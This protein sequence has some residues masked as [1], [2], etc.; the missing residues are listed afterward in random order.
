[1]DRLS[2]QEL[3]RDYSERRSEPA[4]AELV[5]RHVDLVYSA[6]LRMVGDAHLAEDVTQGAFSALAQNA[7]QLSDRSVLAG[8]LHRTARNLAA[9][10]VRG[11][12]RRR[13]REQ[14]AAAMN[15]L[16]STES[17]AVWEK[18]APHL[19]AALDDLSEPD[20]DALLL[21]YFER[22]SAHEIA[23]AF[24]ISDDAAQKR[25]SRAVERLREFFSKR[26]VA[27]GASGVVI[28][29]SA[30]AVQAAPI[31][32][33]A[34]ISSTAILTGTTATT[35][36]ATKAIAMTLIQ[37]TL[38]AATVTALVGTSVYEAHRTAQLGEQ[39]QTLQQQQAPLTAQ[40]QELQQQ[41]D[42]ASNQVASLT[43]ELAKSDKNDFEL[44]K[45]RGEVG[46]LRKQLA[47]VS[48]TPF[49]KSKPA[50]NP[51]TPD[52]AGQ[53]ASAIAQ[54]DPTALRRLN[55]FAKSQSQY[56]QTNSV[57]LKNEELTAVWSKSFSGL[58]AAFDS[59]S[60]E[61]IKGNVNAR[62]AIDQAT[63][64]GPLQGP[65]VTSLGKLAAKGDESALQM[66]L[67]PD[68]NGILLSSVVGALGPAAENGNPQAIAF[69]ANVLSDQTK[70]PL[71]HMASEPLRTAAAF[72]NQS[73][74]DALK[75][76]P[77]QP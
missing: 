71:W 11:D 72:G 44:L 1:M 56:Y 9:N 60:D 35:V 17:D 45:L 42:D 14:E 64:L 49:Q 2:D 4:F 23:Q 51:A 46:A 39:V 55:D 38:I 34:S 53:I 3:L 27:I 41:R 59:L 10:I 7:R 68:K 32:L 48:D 5:R 18:I 63:Q 20:R 58:L 62:H 25:V 40:I 12:A 21:R 61:A 74:V 66:L 77:Q 16:L 19:D 57:G 73:A 8:W 31:A 50:E 26:G 22:K 28:L 36:I 30:N 69:L 54:G 75:S 6:A 67:A 29:I 13:A 37:K 47:Q 33:V 52:E 24:G 76:A 65:A 43:E 70:K 15:E